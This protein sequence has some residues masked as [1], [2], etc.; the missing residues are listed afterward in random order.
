MHSWIDMQHDDSISNLIKPTWNLQQCFWVN[1]EI[2]SLSQHKP[3]SRQYLTKFPSVKSAKPQRSTTVATLV[4]CGLCSSL[5]CCF[6][7]FVEGSRAGL[8]WADCRAPR[9]ILCAPW[10][11]GMWRASTWVPRVFWSSKRQVL[12]DSGSLSFQGRKQSG[13][14]SGSHRW[15]K[16]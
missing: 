13:K 5:V 12:V 9:G 3:M 8:C 16:T 14:Q 4:I 15:Q 10:Q 6:L 2:S 1:H 11:D 7:L